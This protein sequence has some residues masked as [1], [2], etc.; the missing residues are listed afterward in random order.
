MGWCDA[1]PKDET[2]GYIGTGLLK[3]YRGQGIGTQLLGQIIELSKQYGYRKL[4][5]DVRA[6]NERAV[7]VYKKLGFTPYNIVENGFRLGESMVSEN[8]IQMERHL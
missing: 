5:L 8:V 6:S 7:H 1:L 3:A 2:I 4:E